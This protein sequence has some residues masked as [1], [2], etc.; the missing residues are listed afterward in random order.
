MNMNKFEENTINYFKGR[1]FRSCAAMDLLNI[2]LNKRSKVGESRK[3]L[4]N[5]SLLTV[6]KELV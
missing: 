6:L 2:S 1:D 4:R 5:I 3:K